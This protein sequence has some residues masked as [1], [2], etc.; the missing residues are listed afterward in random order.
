MQVLVIGSGGRE[1]AI[2]K[3]LILDSKINKLY[4]APGNAGIAKDAICVAI[5]ANDIAAIVKFSLTEKIDF[6]VVTPDDP[7]VLGMVDALEAVGIAAFGPKKAAAILEGSK[8]FAKDF[9]QKYKIP[10]ANYKVVEEYQEAAAYIKK[11]NNY[12]VV[13]KADGLALGKGVII[14]NTEKEAIETLHAL[15]SEKKF[16]I[17]S[18]KVVIEEFLTGIE[19]SVLTF[20]DGKTIVPLTAAMDHKR[21]SDTDLGLNTGGM[22]AIAL[23]P[24]YTEEI[25]KIC[26]D[27]IYLP[28][29]QG[30]ETENRSFQGV[31]YFGLMLTESGPYVIEYNC[32][33]GDPEA[34]VVLPLLEGDLLEIM[35]AVR[36]GKLIQAKIAEKSGFAACIILASEGYPS[37]YKIGYKI[38]GIEAAEQLPDIL[39]YHAGTKENEGIIVTNG[40]RVLGITAISSSLNDALKKAYACAKQISFTGMQYRKDIGKK[41]GE[42]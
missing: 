29:I 16:G 36:N 15:L 25:A 33:F 7:L 23:H 13:L 19:V 2:I 37:S 26:M 14:V 5:K 24:A 28:T 21:I 11:Q 35:Q 8:A 42:Y 9:M 40:G 34:E 12:P 31:L 41:A 4:A 38:H 6:V 39:V 3:K 22:G 1:H 10:T 18:S 32:R 27:K 20:T 30:M 17:S